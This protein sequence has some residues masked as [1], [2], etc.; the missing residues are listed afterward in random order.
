M[1]NISTIISEL[2]RT[3]APKLSKVGYLLDIDIKDP[4]FKPSHPSAIK[5]ACEIY[6]NFLLRESNKNHFRGKGIITLSVR[7]DKFVLKDS[8]TI[9]KSD[10]IAPFLALGTTTHSDIS[11]RSRLGYGT[12]LSVA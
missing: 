4:S 2:Y 11:V 9:I 7:G 3:F 12:T 5:K 1:Q 10:E 8:L 6:F